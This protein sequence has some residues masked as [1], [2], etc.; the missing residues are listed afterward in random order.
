MMLQSVRLTFRNHHNPWLSSQTDVW[1][2]PSYN[3]GNAGNDV[4]I[5]R[6]G[7]TCKIIFFFKQPFT[8]KPKWI[9]SQFLWV[10]FDSALIF[11]TPIKAGGAR[12]LKEREEGEE[13]AGESEEIQSLSAN[14][15]TTAAK[16]FQPHQGVFCVKCRDMQENMWARLRDSGPGMCVIL[17]T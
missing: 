7:S 3:T 9:D 12:S 1:F 10:R 13:R 15:I 4:A 6:S 8:K 2:R 17:A 16:A 11:T 14:R 5:W